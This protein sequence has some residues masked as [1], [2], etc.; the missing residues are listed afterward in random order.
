MKLFFFQRGYNNGG[1]GGGPN[2]EVSCSSLKH[3]RQ[4]GFFLEL[5]GIRKFYIVD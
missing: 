5:A 4:T 1:G 3:V 2:D